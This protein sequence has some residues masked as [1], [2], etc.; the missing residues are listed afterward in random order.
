MWSRSVE[1]ACG[2]SSVELEVWC[3]RCEVGVWIQGCGVR[4]LESDVESSVESVMWN[5]E[6]GVGGVESGC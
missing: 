4:S 3:R 6:S 1:S 5:W 2:V